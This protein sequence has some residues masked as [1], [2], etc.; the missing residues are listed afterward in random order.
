MRVGN[1]DVDVA[2]VNIFT[3]TTKEKE[4]T[5]S[6]AIRNAINAQ[7]SNFSGYDRKY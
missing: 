4:T 5:I 3:E 6:N 7:P 1:Q 2:V